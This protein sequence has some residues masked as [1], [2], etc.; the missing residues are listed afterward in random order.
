MARWTGQMD[1][2]LIYGQTCWFEVLLCTHVN[3]MKGTT[4]I[5]QAP[6][7]SKRGLSVNGMRTKV[8][9]C[10]HAKCMQV[11]TRVG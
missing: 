10:A 3:E 5:A 11:D 6:L 4:A 7:E 1:M 9:W 8:C 2:L